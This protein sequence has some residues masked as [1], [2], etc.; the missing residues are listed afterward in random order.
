M[1]KKKN[2]VVARGNRIDTETVQ[3]DHVLE[4]FGLCDAHRVLSPRL[5][6][7]RY[8][9]RNPRNPNK[10]LDRNLEATT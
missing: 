9:A 10:A 7:T 6:A 8:L 1:P 4:A 3:L 2:S 5:C